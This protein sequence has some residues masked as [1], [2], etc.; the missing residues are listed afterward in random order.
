MGVGIRVNV[1]YEY[2]QRTKTRWKFVSF[3][4]HALN[5]LDNSA[6]Y[7]LLYKFAHLKF[8]QIYSIVIMFIIIV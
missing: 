7:V 6:C 8:P 2:S 5:V 1:F 4:V 3:F